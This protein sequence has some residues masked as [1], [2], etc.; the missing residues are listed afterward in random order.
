MTQTDVNKSDYVLRLYVS[1][2]TPHSVAAIK[3]I[4]N[5]C[6]NKLQGHYKLEIID[7]YQKPV[8]AKNAQIIAVP[9]LVKRQPEPQR[10]LCGD[11][12]ETDKVLLGLGIEPDAL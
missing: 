6:R 12:S 7:I 8:E 3:N 11:M 1:G 2:A 10:R 9:T 4:T 5:I